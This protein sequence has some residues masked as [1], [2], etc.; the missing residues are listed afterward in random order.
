M[1]PYHGIPENPGGWLQ[2]TAKYQA[3]DL[4]RR[5][6]AFQKRLGRYA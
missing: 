2:Q 3:L 1:W 4:L 5:E 6:H